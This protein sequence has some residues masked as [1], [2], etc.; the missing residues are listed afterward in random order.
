MID[1]KR[2]EELR[3]E[4]GE[5]DFNE[6]V[7]LFLDETDEVAMNLRNDMAHGAIESALHFLKGSALNLG[8]TELAALCQA[9]EKA[10]AQGHAATVDLGL[11]LDSYNRS[12]H[13]FEQGK[14]KM[15]AA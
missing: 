13:A 5:D 8:F 4:I 6:V 1:W 15:D 7:A 12:K 2:V 3:D 9:G 11:V 14:A 10:A